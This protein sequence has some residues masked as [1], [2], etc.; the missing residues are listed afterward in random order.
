MDEFYKGMGDMTLSE[1]IEVFGQEG[2]VMSPESYVDDSLEFFT[3]YIS[4]LKKQIDFDEILKLAQKYEVVLWED[5]MDLLNTLSSLDKRISEVQD[6]VKR[7]EEENNKN[8]CRRLEVLRAISMLQSDKSY[9]TIKGEGAVRMADP[10]FNEYLPV[11]LLQKLFDDN[12]LF[13]CG[14]MKWDFE[15]PPSMSLSY[16]EKFIAIEEDMIDS[17]ELLGK[18]N[19][20]DVSLMVY[21]LAH[22]LCRIDLIESSA[23]SGARG[24]VYER[25]GL[26]KWATTPK[27]CFI[28]EVL[29]FY[30][31]LPSDM[32]SK[33]NQEKYQF[34]KNKIGQALRFMEYKFKSEKY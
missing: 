31:V 15:N 17:Y 6:E 30:G 20:R 24:F 11:V 25:S 12:K 21:T 13:Y 32:N 22:A 7:L 23:K 3:D 8:C 28:V 9:I 29:V 1:P 19:E 26:K 5:D 34:V 10:I 33:K 16:L 4:S 27:A 2:E 14:H 18:D